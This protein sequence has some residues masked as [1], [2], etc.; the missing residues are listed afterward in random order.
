[1]AL[2]REEMEFHKMLQALA[3]ACGHQLDEF[4]M[5]VYDRILSP[6]GYDQVNAALWE[7]FGSR[8]GGDRFPSIGDIKVMMGVDY[9]PRSLA[10]DAANS[11]FWS[12]NKWKKTY[13]DREN[14]EQLYREKIGDLPWEVCSRMGGYQA[15]Y[16]EW[17]EAGDLSTLRA[18]VRDAALAY[19]DLNK[20]DQSALIESA[21]K[22]LGGKK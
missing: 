19:L 13:C 18:Q 8:R 4:S 1:M 9:S 10:V 15:L 16:K 5:E 17:C 2:S 22:Q 11:I 21:T 14:F 12:F 7:I 3:V 20:L 6:F